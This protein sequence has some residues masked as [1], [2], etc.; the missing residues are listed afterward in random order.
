MAQTFLN[1]IN[2]KW[3]ASKSAKTYENRNPANWNDVIGLFQDSNTD[4][5]EEAVQAAR[6][7]FPQ[8]RDTPAPKRAEVLYRTGELLV[9]D[10][11]FLAGDLTREMGKVLNEA[12]GDVQEAVDMAYYIAG[13]GRRL[14]GQTTPSEL[15]DKIC[16]TTRVPLGVVAA[17]TPWNFPIAIPS[18]KI[19]PA[20]LA[21]NTVVFKPSPE[22]P[23]SAVHFVKLLEK[24]GLPPGV[25]NLVTGTEPELG[26]GLTRHPEVNLVAFTGST[27]TGRKVSES[28]GKNL[29]RFSL[30][31]GGKNAVIVD[32]DA[33]LD[34]AL[35]GTLWAAFGTSGQR[36]TSTSRLI[37][38][39]KIAKKFSGILVKK[40][41]DLRCGD[42]LD[43]THHVGPLINESQLKRVQQYVGV[44]L[45]E[46]AKLLLGG[47]RCTDENCKDGWFFKPTIFTDVNSS[48]R[49]ARE[50]I[51]GPVLSIL[52][53]DNLDEAVEIANNTSYG[54][55]SSIYTK[56]IHKALSV[57]GRFETGVSYINAPT[58]GAEVHLPFGGFK[59]TGNGH[60]DGGPAVMDTYTEW[61]T[62]YVDYSS[63]L[64]K[65]QMES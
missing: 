43:K 36:C 62:L 29:K 39:T 56:N 2:G 33:D 32:E 16:L 12:E 7:A 8:W 45:K 20:I 44:G 1:F 4:D 52:E 51:F 55:S 13:E 59:N 23:L 31:L 28:C 18:W 49:I 5:L 22:V 42:G 48:M 38:H 15:T 35:E 30:E 25:V 9:R 24:A 47:G 17:V 26:A 60:R 10:K 14:F 57:A 46:G 19:F 41:K 27:K 61:K 3:L 58:I 37:L 40:A 53:A 54:L 21:G 34:L 64:Q 65:A 6:K 63:R 50:E 11:S